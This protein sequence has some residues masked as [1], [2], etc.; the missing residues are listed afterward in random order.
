MKSLQNLPLDHIRHCDKEAEDLEKKKAN[1][2]EEK[3]NFLIGGKCQ[4]DN[5][6]I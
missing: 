6:A 4:T 3:D 1:L 5:A 2:V